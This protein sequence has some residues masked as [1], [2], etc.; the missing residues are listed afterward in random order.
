MTNILPPSMSAI[1]AERPF[2]T[3]ERGLLKLAVKVY[4][5][6]GLAFVVENVA[7]TVSDVAL[8]IALM[9]LISAPTVIVSPT[10][11]WVVNDVF[12]P[13][14]VADPFAVMAVPAPVK[15]NDAV[16]LMRFGDFKKVNDAAEEIDGENALSVV[17]DVPLAILATTRA[18]LLTIIVSPTAN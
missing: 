9:V 5:R 10:I 18:W 15:G 17:S 2:T 7:L 8:A 12:S 6:P 16:L 1:Y 4:A 13:V 14:T 3:T 11:S